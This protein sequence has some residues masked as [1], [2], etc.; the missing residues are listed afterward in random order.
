MKKGT[1]KVMAGILAMAMIAEATGH[2]DNFG[3]P[4]GTKTAY[5]P[6][7]KNYSNEF[8]QVIKKRRKKN[9]AARKARKRNRK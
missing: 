5:T 1:R 3:N 8:I 9:K 2:A 6:A 7:P 4:I